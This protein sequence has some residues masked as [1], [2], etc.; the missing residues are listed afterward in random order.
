MF[1]SGNQAGNTEEIGEKGAGRYQILLLGTKKIG[2]MI[3]GCP[4]F[5]GNGVTPCLHDGS[6][7]LRMELDAIDAGTVPDCLVRAVG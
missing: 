4:G 6:I 3:L 5:P 2:K 1:D 7:H